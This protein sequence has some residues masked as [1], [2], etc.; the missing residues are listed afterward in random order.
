MSTTPTFQHTFKSTAQIELAQKRLN[1]AWCVGIVVVLGLAVAGAGL[2]AIPILFTA[3]GMVVTFSMLTFTNT[4]LLP[5]RHWLPPELCGEL[6]ECCKGNSDL[7]GYRN[8]V[9]AEGRRFTMGEY[10]AMMAWPDQKKRT[11]REREEMQAQTEACKALY[12][13]AAI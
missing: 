12:D 3:A 8:Q 4:A 2:S 10:R 5:D 1:L 13:Q 7:T 9:L 11:L 6:L